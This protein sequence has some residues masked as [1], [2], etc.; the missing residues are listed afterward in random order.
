MQSGPK[1]STQWPMVSFIIPTLNVEAYYPP[2]PRMSSFCVYV[3]HL[4]HISDP[5][6]WL[7]S[8][9]PILVAREGEIERWTLPGDSLSYPLGANGFV[10]R[11][12]DLDSVK[13]DEHFQD[14]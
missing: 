3:T 10:F 6:C 5:I 9:N 13:A 11:R 8:R 14:T 1:S 12:S 4:L 7:M 2:S